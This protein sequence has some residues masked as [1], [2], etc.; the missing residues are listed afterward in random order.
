MLLSRLIRKILL[1]TVNIHLLVGVAYASSI[2]GVIESTGVNSL[3][4]SSSD[5]AAQ[6][7][8][9]IQLNDTAKT[10]KGRMLIK[11]ADEAELSLIEHSVVYIDKVYY[12]PDPSKSKMV[13][14]MAMGTARFASGRLGMVNKKNIEISTPTA[15]IAV[16]G[17]DFTTTTD[18]LGRSLVILLPDEYGN[19]SGEIVVS[20][21]AGE[22]TLSEAYAATMVSSIS[23]APTRTVVIEGI[24][25][26]VIDNMFI[27]N[28]PKEVRQVMEEQLQ[29]LDSDDYGSL[30]ADYL[31]FD[32]LEKDIDDYASEDVDVTSRLDYNAL[33]SELLVDLLDIVEELVRTLEALEDVQQNAGGATILKGAR[34]GLNSDSQYAIFAEDDGLVF[35]RDAGGVISLNFSNGGSI[36]VETEV[37]GYNG[38]ITANGGEDIR[39]I[40]RQGN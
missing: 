13:M 2:G 19:P 8:T 3:E 38:I 31:A 40:I 21:E 17:T 11:F 30:D 39:V 24:T 29:E 23:T 10:A 36:R 33:D 14:K 35:Y 34:W 1:T 5:I 20:N 6:V 26:T 18:E 12:D 9:E 37:D 25:P 32:E 27:V 16:R 7:G 22:I 4:R 28:P 15:T